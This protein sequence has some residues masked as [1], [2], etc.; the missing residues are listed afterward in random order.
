MNADNP[1]EASQRSTRPR[2]HREWPLLLFFPAGVAFV[3]V[4]W[5]PGNALSFAEVLALVLGILGA[6]VIGMGCFRLMIAAR[7]AQARELHPDGV[8]FEAIR[9]TVTDSMLRGMSTTGLRPAYW[10]IVAVDASG[11]YCYLRDPSDAECVFIPVSH[12]VRVEMGETSVRDGYGSR[13]VPAIM[14][15]LNTAEPVALPLV[16]RSER[17]NAMF[18]YAASYA[19]RDQLLHL[20]RELLLPLERRTGNAN[21]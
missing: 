18:R 9:A 21:Q 16:P 4:L 1:W 20:L 2:W 12:V 15:G 11:L 5:R 8:V 10:S 3:L 13:K 7:F 19:D 17:W 6:F 14:V